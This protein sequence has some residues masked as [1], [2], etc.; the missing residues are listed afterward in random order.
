MSYGDFERCSFGLCRH[1]EKISEASKHPHSVRAI[2]KTTGGGQRKRN[3]KKF[4][5]LPSKCE[6]ETNLQCGAKDHPYGWGMF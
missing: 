1:E 4:A 6:V 2:K 5:N 3:T